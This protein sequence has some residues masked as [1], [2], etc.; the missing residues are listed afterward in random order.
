MSL[1]NT[2][3]IFWFF[4][5]GASCSSVKQL[6]VERDISDILKKSEVFSKHHTGF[7]LYDL[8]EDRFLSDYNASLLFTPASNT[9]LLTMYASLKS[10][11]DSIPGI[12]YSKV[13]T[14]LR[15]HPTG[16]PTFLL[17][18]FG[19]QPVLKFLK[20][21]Q[22]IEVLFPESIA[23]Y[24]PGWAWDDYS[25]SFQASRTWWPIY[26]N[27]VRIIKTDS[28]V[29]ITPTFFS[30]YIEFS[31]DNSKQQLLSRDLRYNKFTV[32]S[33]QD[34]SQIDERIPFAY[35]QE[36]FL[37]LLSDTLKVP[38]AQ[39]EN[40]IAE[41]D[42][43]Y[44]QHID[45]VLARMM[46]PSDNF[47]AEQLLIMSASQNG[48]DKIDEYIEYLRT[49]HLSN[50][51]EMVWV[52]GSGLSRYNLIAPNDQVRLL[53]SCLDEFGWDRITNILPTGGEGTLKDLYLSETPFIYA[54][55]GTLSNNHNLSGILI[56]Q[57][58][59]R[60]IFSLMNNHYTRPTQEVKQA[61]ENFLLQIKTSY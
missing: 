52:D 50:L 33:P 55:T 39:T 58:G 18:E 9:K 5:I 10:F 25:Y 44:S 12:T 43:L 29:S 27:M 23:S 3:L 36:L 37:Q 45:T 59:K 34:T 35:S 51:N 46:K 47:L 17:P 21:Q 53:K 16:D 4:M 11:K 42:T 31:N 30:D 20:N 41:K 28:S 48:F 54:K 26:G 6:A 49:V 61:I 7:S 13:D 40:H 8:E 2:P 32:N 38:V 19:N 24:G 22:A 57:S 1:R 56:T 60:L 15:I 14:I